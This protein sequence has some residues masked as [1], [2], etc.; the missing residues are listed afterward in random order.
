M[1]SSQLPHQVVVKIKRR[2]CT[3]TFSGNYGGLYKVVKIV[4]CRALTDCPVEQQFLFS[5]SCWGKPGLKCRDLPES[6]HVVG[7][8]AGVHCFYQRAEERSMDEDFPWCSGMCLCC[9]N[10]FSSR[11][12][13]G[14]CSSCYC[15]MQSSAKFLD[16]N[17]GLGVWEG[18]GWIFLARGLSCCCRQWLELD[19][20]GRGYWSSWEQPRHL[21]GPLH[22][23]WTTLSFLTAWQPWGSWT[24]NLAA[25]GSPGTRRK[26][27][28]C[29]LWCSFRSHTASLTLYWNYCKWITTPPRFKRRLRPHLSMWGAASF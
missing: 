5:F 19:E 10:R 14:A 11:M 26:Q 15:C 20:L 24:A 25:Q 7:D 3:W 16:L 2:Q 6:I 27:H 28:H 13:K 22:I 21:S 4:I 23:V 18:L 17:C 9:C 8:K 1:T 12:E 29:L